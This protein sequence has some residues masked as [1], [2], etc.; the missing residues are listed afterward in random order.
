LNTPSIEAYKWWPG[1]LG[2]YATHALV[3]AQIIV[4]GKKKGVYPLMIQ[5][6]DIKTHR[7]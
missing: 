6:R 1:E 2:V 4:N 5:I 3:Y 7:V